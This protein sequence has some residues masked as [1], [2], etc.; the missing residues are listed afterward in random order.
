MLGCDDVVYGEHEFCVADDLARIIVQ[1]EIC[2]GLSA[3]IADKLSAALPQPSDNLLRNLLVQVLEVGSRF[4]VGSVQRRRDDADVQPT[5]QNLS[6]A[7]CRQVFQKGRVDGAAAFHRAD[8]PAATV[9]NGSDNPVAQ[10][11]GANLR[12]HN[13][14][15]LRVCRLDRLPGGRKVAAVGAGIVRTEEGGD[16]RCV[17][18]ELGNVV[19]F[20][21]G[22]VHGDGNGGQCL[23]IPAGK[24]IHNCFAGKHRIQQELAGNAVAVH[25]IDE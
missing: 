10:T 2:L 24:G 14:P 3:L 18:V 4:D 16:F 6:R 25:S 23:P 5:V 17:E 15:L 12:P 7:G 20:P 1:W 22:L 11:A 9:R 19:L 8:M 13:Q 21:H